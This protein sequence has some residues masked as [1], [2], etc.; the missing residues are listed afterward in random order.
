MPKAFL[1][2][3][4]VKWL[5]LYRSG[6]TEKW[7]AREQ[8]KCDIRTV[9]RGIEEARRKQY[10]RDAGVELIKEALRKHQDSLL[11]ELDEILSNLVVPQYAFAT[12]S[13]QYNGKSVSLEHESPADGQ[14]VDHS[15]SG[16]QELTLRRLLRQHLKNDRLWKALTLWEKANAAHL[17]AQTRL[18]RATVSLL[19]QKTGYKLAG[20]GDVPPPVLYSYT[21]GNLV[22]SMVLRYAFGSD[23]TSELENEILAHP[24]GGDVTY[25][26]TIL[27]KAPGNEEGTKQSILSTVRELEASPEA[28]LV[29]ST[30]QTLN[31]MTARARR[32]VEEIKLLG[33]IFG[34]CEVCRRLGV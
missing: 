16:R 32:V 34:Q 27:A 12:F 4:K 1:E 22:F 31:D 13:W 30:Y 24:E 10:A 9:K 18:Q 23:K 20:P 14:V 5:E 29:V 11:Q 3:D 6:K 17:S 28:R 19:E 21:V 33:L 26:D 2:T 7:I 15:R 25:R 8:A